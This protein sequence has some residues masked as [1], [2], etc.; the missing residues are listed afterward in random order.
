MVFV[1][2][3]LRSII[4]GLLHHWKSSYVVKK[5]RNFIGSEMQALNIQEE[6]QGI[7]Y[8]E[9]YTLFRS[10]VRFGILCGTLCDDLARKKVP[11]SSGQQGNDPIGD[12]YIFMPQRLPPCGS[13]WPGACDH[14]LVM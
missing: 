6:W 8:D 13:A 7:G 3:S 12:V 5:E 9:S 4:L 14:L 2:L 1:C 10:G 11:S